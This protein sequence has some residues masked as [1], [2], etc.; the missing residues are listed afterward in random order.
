MNASHDRHLSTSVSSRRAPRACAS[1]SS[2]AR[3][4]LSDDSSISS[5][6]RD[7]PPTRLFPFARRRRARRWSGR[8]NHLPRRPRR[9]HRARRALALSN[10]HLVANAKRFAR[11]VP[12]ERRRARRHRAHVVRQRPTREHFLRD[13]SRH[14]HDAVAQDQA[15][16]PAV[17]ARRVRAR[18]RRPRVVRVAV[19]LLRRPRPRA[20]ARRRH[21]RRR[22]RRPRRS[23]AAR[24]STAPRRAPCATSSSR[25]DASPPAQ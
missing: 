12:H 21:R 2:R 13:A 8:R 6:T 22:R 7:C 15:V 3:S 10:E 24:A 19:L 20:R 11:P 17:D 4:V 18:R 16:D 1:F 5:S 14:V 25:T 23:S 9:P